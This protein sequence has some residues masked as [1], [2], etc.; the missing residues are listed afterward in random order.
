VTA[1]DSA[2]PRISIC[3]E[4][5][6]T[7]EFA[8]RIDRRTNVRVQRLA[9]AL[10]A[11]LG[12]AAIRAL[13]PAYRSLLVRYDPWICSYERLCQVVED[14]LAAEPSGAGEGAPAGRRLEIPVCY[15]GAYGPDLEAL[16][17]A[18]G[19]TPQEA[20]ALHSAADYCVYMIGFTPGYC[21]LGGL[22]ERLA[23]PRRKEPR[24]QVPAGSVGIAERQTGI[25]SIASPGGWQIVGRTPLVLFAPQRGDPFLLRPG[26]S[27]RFRPISTEEFEDARRS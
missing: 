27:I 23:T 12:S 26:D 15:G 17:A 4:C 14:C 8:E 16:A 13:I 20:A 24:L 18:R 1:S 6:V 5:A 21:Y 7:V 9:A 11:H 3:G 19:L 22:D 10:P 2:P 25:Y